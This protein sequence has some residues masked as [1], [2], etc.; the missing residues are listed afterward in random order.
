MDVADDLHP[1]ALVLSTRREGSRRIVVVSGELDLDTADEFR[2]AIADLLAERV[3]SVEVDAAGLGFADSAGLR[4][5][6]L[7]R[8][9][10][11]AAGASFGVTVASPN[12]T[13]VMEITGLTDLFVD[14]S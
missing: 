6:L 8:N 4:A 9:A 13:R 10:A 11:E 14:G 12:V 2:T 1:A 3:S 7:A 5:L